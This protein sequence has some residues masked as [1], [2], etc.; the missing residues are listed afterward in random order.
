MKF[1]KPKKD[2]GFDKVKD[3]V[4]GTITV[5]EIAQLKDAYEHFCKTPGIELVNIKEK[6]DTLENITVNFV[7]CD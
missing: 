4:R 1:L 2:Q 5:N 3:L 6:L 7:F